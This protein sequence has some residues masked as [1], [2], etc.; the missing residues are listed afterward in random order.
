MLPFRPS[1]AGIAGDIIPELIHLWIAIRDEPE[2]I[3]KEYTLRWK[4]LQNEGHKAYYEIRDAFNTTRN[5]HD[6][7]FLSRTCVNGLIRF[8]KNGNFN[9]SLHH[10][11]PGIEPER[12]SKLVFQWS[13]F[14]QE[15]TFLVADYHQ[16]L[17]NAKL[18]D[19]VF[20]DP[21][22]H[23][24]KGRYIPTSFDFQKFYLEL[25]RLNHIGVKWVLTFDGKAGER[26]YQVTVPTNLYK[27]VLG[28]PTGNSPFTKLMKISLDTV[29]ES[30]YL[31]FEPPSETL[32]Q[33]MNFGQK[34]VGHW[35]DHNMQQS[36]LFN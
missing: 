20:L 2:L 19:L 26:A 4:R 14:T 1:Q 16:T 27:T 24:T 11:R 32:S 12:L 36:R 8:N 23:G 3:T 28:L 34:K 5:P 17:K 7:L 10:T 21:P 33:I 29:I 18:G 35:S 22:Y 31:N 30:V 6:F 9:N 13:R 25:E 15:V